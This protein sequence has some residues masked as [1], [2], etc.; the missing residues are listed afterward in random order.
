[1]RRVE[2]VLEQSCCDMMITGTKRISP[3]IRNLPLMKTDVGNIFSTVEIDIFIYKFDKFLGFLD[4]G[5]HVQ[6]IPH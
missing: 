5:F 6:R 2:N 1:M 3:L 4:M